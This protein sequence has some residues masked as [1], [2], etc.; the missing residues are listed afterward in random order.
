MRILFSILALV[1]L[2]KTSFAACPDGAEA[3]CEGK[4]LGQAISIKDVFKGKMYY[5][6]AICENDLESKDECPV[7]CMT[8]K[9]LSRLVTSNAPIWRSMTE[10]GFKDKADVVQKTTD[11]LKEDPGQGVCPSGLIDD[12]SKNEAQDTKVKEATEHIALLYNI[13][14][15]ITDVN[16]ELLHPLSA[17]NPF[18]PPSPQSSAK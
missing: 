16:G 18:L 12:K 6:V 15:G 13:Q 3:L 1:F 9:E 10:L 4:A 11:F 17:I 7:R 8:M 5:K 14:M 2:S